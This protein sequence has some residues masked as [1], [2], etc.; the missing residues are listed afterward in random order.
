MKVFYFPSWQD[1]APID[2]L[3]TNCGDRLEAR[4]IAVSQGHVVL[5]TTFKLSTIQLLYYLGEYIYRVRLLS[6][7]AYATR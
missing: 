3:D 1:R 7:D 4:V 2:N 6:R 5:L